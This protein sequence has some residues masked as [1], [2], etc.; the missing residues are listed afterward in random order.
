VSFR[1]P[2]T[3]L[4]ASSITA[5]TLGPGV[6]IPAPQISSGGFGAGVTMPAPQITTGALASG[7][8]LPAGQLTTGALTATY[9]ITGAIQ[10]AATGAR[11]AIDSTGVRGYSATGQ[12]FAID[13]STGAVSIAGTFTIAT[14]TS[15]SRVVIDNTGIFAYNGTTQTLGISAITG[16]VVIVGDF[17]TGV[18]GTQ[19]VQL[20][21]STVDLYTGY[22]AEVNPSYLYGAMATLTGPTYRGETDV[23]SPTTADYP[24][25]GILVNAAGKAGTLPLLTYNGNVLTSSGYVRGANL[26]A[27]TG[28]SVGIIAGTGIHVYAGGILVDAGGIAVT[29]WLNT[30]GMTSTGSVT[31]TYYHSSGGYE[32]FASGSVTTSATANTTVT[33]PAGRFTAAPN[34]VVQP[35]QNAFAATA[36]V[37]GYSGNEATGSFTC[38]ATRITSGSATVSAV[39]ASLAWIAANA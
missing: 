16:N 6:T 15:G 34:V 13:A 33:L 11:V 19:R 22:A 38:F 8:T 39:A 3:S 37:W 4:P 21:G 12:T 7:V 18:A 28:L 31:A 2:T 1:N 29:G 30:D 25:P 9:T 23:Y 26:I 24:N 32:N 5:G 14:A 20:S 35:R 17:S 27:D 10:T 36:A